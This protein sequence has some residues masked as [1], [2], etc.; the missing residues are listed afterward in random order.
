MLEYRGV[1][2]EI[3]ESFQGRLFITDGDT[4]YYSDLGDPTEWRDDPAN[5]KYGGLIENFQGNTDKITALKDYG[6]YLAIY[7]AN[8][9]YLLSGDSPD[10]FT[11]TKFGS[12]GVNSSFCPCNFN[13]KQF[14][15]A[16][17]NLDLYYLGLFGDLCQLQISDSISYRIK[18]LIMKDID[19]SRLDEI[20]ILPYFKRNQIW[21]YVPV[22]GQDYLS[23][24]YVFD[25][26]YP[27]EISPAIYKRV[28]NINITAGMVF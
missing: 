7:T 21:M 24:C 1:A 4:L 23:T 8:N 10:N 28:E 9:I 5:Q 13:N 11:I 12:M 19:T 27:T 16:S 14:F 25:F 3:A 26:N 22:I 18:T 6:E 17:K 20:I 15:F 2:G